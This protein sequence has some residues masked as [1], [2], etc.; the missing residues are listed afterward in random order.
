M[1][2]LCLGGQWDQVED[3]LE[4]ELEPANNMRPESTWEMKFKTPGSSLQLQGEGIVRE[5]GM[6]TC[7]HCYI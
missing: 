4:P 1:T 6:D 2:E 3:S 5:L 7:T